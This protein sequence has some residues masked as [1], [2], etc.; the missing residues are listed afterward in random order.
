MEN[1]R[2]VDSGTEANM[3]A[4]GAAIAYTEHSKILIFHKG[5]HRSIMSVYQTEGKPSIN[6]SHDFAVAP[7][8]GV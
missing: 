3:M 5:Y 7:Y 4:L 1:I 8:H 2:S 6:L